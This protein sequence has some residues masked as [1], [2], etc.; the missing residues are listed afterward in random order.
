MQGVFGYEDAC[1]QTES[2]VETDEE[3]ESA[4]S[5]SERHWAW[6]WY[7]R[8]MRVVPLRNPRARGECLETAERVV[9]G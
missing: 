8:G 7:A 9:G 3:K 2:Q 6:G 4:G 1:Y 5:L